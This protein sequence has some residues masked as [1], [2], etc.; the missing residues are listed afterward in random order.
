LAIEYWSKQSDAPV[1]V[2]ESYQI[3]PRVPELSGKIENFVRTPE[4]TLRRIVGPCQYHPREWTSEEEQ[5]VA[6]DQDY[7]YPLDGVHHH[8]LSNGRDV[9]LCVMTKNNSIYG[10]TYGVWEHQGWR[11]SWKLLIGDAA[12]AELRMALIESERPRPLVQFVS[13]PNG[14]VIL[15]RDGRACFYDG[16]I[17]APLGYDRPPGAPTPLG[18]QAGFSFNSNVYVDDPNAS[19]YNLTGR[20]MNLAL[21][22]GRIGTV[23]ASLTDIADTT[24]SSNPAGGVLMAG[25]WRYALQYMDLWGN[26]SPVS[27]KS[28][29]VTVARTDNLSKDRKKDEAELA[30]RLKHQFACQ[31]ISRG[32]TYTMARIVGRTRDMLNSGVPDLFELPSHATEGPLQLAT[33]PDNQCTFY[34]DNIPDSW[35]IN[36]M[37]QVAEMPMASYGALAM[38]RLWVANWPNARGAIM[39]SYPGRWGTMQPGTVI[40]PDP[41]AEI[42]GMIS[43]RGGL[44]VFTGSS[45]YLINPNAD[46]DG[47]R[48]ATL[49]TALGCVSSNTIVGLPDGSVIWLSR[50]GFAMYTSEGSVVLHET[51]AD[52]APLVRS[53]PRLWHCRAVAAWDY[54]HSE[55]R[56]WV[57]QETYRRPNICLVFDGTGWRERTDVTASA[58]CV[59]NDSRQYMLA[60]GTA[61]AIRR[62]SGEAEDLV[63]LWV[64]DHEY[65][66][67]HDS[68]EQSCRLDTHWLRT[69]RAD[70]VASPQRMLMSFRETYDGSLGVKVSRDFHQFPYVHEAAADSA[71]GMAL[72]PSDDVPLYWDESILGS[73]RVYPTTASTSKVPTVWQNRRIHQVAFDLSVPSS[74]TFRLRL[75]SEHDVEVLSM[76][77]TEINQHLGGVKYAK[78][79]T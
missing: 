45:S 33:V 20:T 73:T 42:T 70:K 58:V 54:A 55:Y 69:T 22:M 25:Q 38:G 72:F 35:L 75:D 2:G 10:D 12:N 24:K 26:L 71:Q 6:A 52:I 40:Y 46:G 60:L 37:T 8:V 57:V 49:S 53:L 64:L 15:F 30:D 7:D 16:F 36:P 41:G 13:V 56:C 76:T 18:P 62:E 48:A 61:S 5:G 68:A 29:P 17:A 77:F 34:P 78:G 31:A 23:D 11:H 19:G 51:N 66:G 79:P 39:C 44:L 50:D 4:G 27:G 14:V 47:F 43:V 28:C 67:V 32:P 3:V 65:F 63:S 21:G 74:S 59:T 9:L 1:L